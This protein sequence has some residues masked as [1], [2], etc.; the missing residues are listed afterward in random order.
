MALSCACAWAAGGLAV[1]VNPGSGV[2]SLS[3]EEVSH[4]FLGRVKFL[5]SGVAAVV[6]DT[7][8]MRESFYR[9]LVDRGI[10]EI[11]AYWARLRFSGRTTPPQVMENAAQVIDR[12]ARERGAIGYVDSALVD[13]RVKAVFELEY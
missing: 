9:A 11:N 3:R 2:D 7:G 13:R 1:I 5:P 8:P 10:A 4:L 6:I 12:V